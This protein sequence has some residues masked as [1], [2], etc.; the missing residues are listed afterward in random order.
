MTS[1]NSVLKRGLEIVSE[2][3]Y[4]L[5]SQKLTTKATIWSAT[6]PRCF[7]N[8]LHKYICSYFKGLLTYYL[9][10]RTM[11]YQAYYYHA[12]T[13][14]DLCHLSTNSSSDRRTTFILFICTRFKWRFSKTP[15]VKT[16]FTI[17]D[18]NISEKLKRQ[19][20]IYTP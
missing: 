17:F 2:V 9:L 8:W 11:I 13:G 19:S 12:H 14:Y 7:D 18:R 10:L 5:K 4:S 15:L 6:R 16:D 1:L 20:Q 3:I